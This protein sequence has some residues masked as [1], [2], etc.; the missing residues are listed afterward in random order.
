MDA[1]TKEPLPGFEN[2]LRAG[3]TRTDMVRCQ[4][5]VEQTRVLIVDVMSR[6]TGDEDED[7][8]GSGDET[9][10]QTEDET[11]GGYGSST[12]YSRDHANIWEEEDERLPM[13][14]ARVYENTLVQL[15][16]SLGNGGA[17]GDV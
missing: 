11:D 9:L 15:G 2:G 14:T 4:S 8:E 6:T 5:L 7:D 13:D 16:E 17:T 12:S 3:L 10:V 1:R